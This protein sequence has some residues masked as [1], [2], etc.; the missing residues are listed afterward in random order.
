MPSL[1]VSPNVLHSQ[2]DHKGPARDDTLADFSYP[3]TYTPNLRGKAQVV[4]QPRWDGLTSSQNGH[5]LLWR[6]P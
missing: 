6:P 4:P 5:T 1:D 2:D 3:E